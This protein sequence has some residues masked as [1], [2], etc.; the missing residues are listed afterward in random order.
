MGGGDLMGSGTGGGGGGGSGGSRGGGGG[1]GSSSRGGGG[2]KNGGTGGY[3]SFQ[4]KDG[5]IKI[6][7]ASRSAKEGMVRNVLHKLSSEYLKSHLAVG[8]ARDLYRELTLLSVDL[9][10]N[11]SWGGVTSRLGVP[12]SP[13]CLAALAANL[14]RRHVQPATEAAIRNVARIAL[15]NCLLRI[16]SDDP[17]IFTTGSANDI[18]GAVDPRAFDRLSNNF[19]G[20][21]LY[22]ILRSEESE[23]PDLSSVVVREIV[24]A[25]ADNLVGA[26]E[27]RFKD[28]PHEGIP[29]VSYRYFFDIIKSEPDWFV[30]ELR[31]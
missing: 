1:G 28:R 14:I 23:L 31:R 5:Q 12:D 18:L 3:G 2:R 29:Q 15:E 4:F 7:D 10:V 9:R 11:R 26:F 21:L 6:V 22:E 16:V 24:Q 30:K 27:S 20:D 17:D 25:K 19:L 8:P 13:G